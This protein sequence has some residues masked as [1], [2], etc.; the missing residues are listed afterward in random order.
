MYL[1]TGAIVPAPTTSLP[2]ET[3]GE[4]NWDYRYA[5]L[6]DTAFTLDIMYR[7]GD[8]RKAHQ[9]MSWLIAQLESIPGRTQMLYG[10]D[11]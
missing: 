3:G 1:H 9:F 6:R 11:P 4:R 10:I 8:T 7:L 5:W 2:E